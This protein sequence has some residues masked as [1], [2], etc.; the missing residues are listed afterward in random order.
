MIRVVVDTNVM[1]SANLSAEG[2]SAFILELAANRKIRVFVS[3]I[4]LEEYETVLRRARLKLDPARVKDSL[5][6]ILKTSTLVRPRGTLSISEDESDNRFYECA[7]AAKAHFW[8]TGNAQT[9]PAQL[10]IH[11]DCYAQRIRRACSSRASSWPT[12]AI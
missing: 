11:P 4:I 8:I 7:E 2:F 5:S 1:V 3:K 10:Q 6:V 12:V 9:L